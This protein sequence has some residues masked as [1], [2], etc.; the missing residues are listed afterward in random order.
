MT[1][2]SVSFDLELVLFQKNVSQ[3]KKAVDDLVGSID[4]SKKDPDLSRLSFSSAFRSLPQS[5]SNSLSLFFL[6]KNQ[7]V[8]TVT[9]NL[10][11]TLILSKMVVG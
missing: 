6:D 5:L 1:T 11:D 7:H 8:S 3:F 9:Y 2:L 10:N 4:R